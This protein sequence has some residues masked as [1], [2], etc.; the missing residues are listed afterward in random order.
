M[1]KHLFDYVQAITSDPS[2]PLDGIKAAF[3]SVDN[4]L[5]ELQEGEG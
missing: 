4:T 2:N 5:I 1:P 3:I